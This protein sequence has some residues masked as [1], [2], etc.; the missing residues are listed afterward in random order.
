MPRYKAWQFATL[1]RQMLPAAIAQKALAGGSPEVADVSFR[2]EL[3]FF[4]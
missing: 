2:D 1:G 4:A 3:A